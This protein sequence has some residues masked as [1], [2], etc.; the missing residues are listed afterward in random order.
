MAGGYF[1]RLF[2]GAPR[3]FDTEG[4]I[5][6]DAR[7][8][9]QFELSAQ[10]TDHPVDFDAIISDHVILKPRIYTLEGV[11]TDTPSD[12]ANALSQIGQTVIDLASFQG[13]SLAG[14][15]FATTDVEQ[16]SSVK[17]SV[18][19]FVQMLDI[20]QAR[21]L[22][23][24]QT[25]L[26]LWEDLAIIQIVVTVDKDTANVLLFRATCKEIRRVAIKEE[27]L[28]K[29]DL[30]GDELES[31]EDLVNEG[32]KQVKDTDRSFLASIR[33]YFRS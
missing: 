14:S 26:G 10:S 33:A 12:I 18:A 21:T 19:S 4:L 24:I 22:I 20:M 16:A 23:N 27:T 32:V 3:G 5:Q 29:D 28:K 6:L 8:S 31:V 15:L 30:Q 9:E 13:S 25:A 11:V 7:I 2:I 17:R 1:Q